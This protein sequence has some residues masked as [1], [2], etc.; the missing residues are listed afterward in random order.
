MKKNYYFLNFFTCCA[1]IVLLSCNQEQ[2]EV[3]EVENL[4]RFEENLNQIQNEIEIKSAPSIQDLQG[5]TYGITQINDQLW[6]TKNHLQTA[7]NNGDKIKEAKNAKEWST[8]TQKKEPIC[9]Y[10][11]YDIANKELYGVYFNWYAV[12]DERGLAPDGWM[13]APNQQVKILTREFI[14]AHPLK[15][16]KHWKQKSLTYNSRPLN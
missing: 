15:Q 12:N 10:Y 5:N 1:F 13:V 14:Y 6:T 9:C 8:A 3:E 7:F 16:E 11:N 2:N 4:I